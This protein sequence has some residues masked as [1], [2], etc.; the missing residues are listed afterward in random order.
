MEELTILNIV[1][2]I[3]TC[4]ANL[5][6]YLRE[7][8]IALEKTQPSS[9]RLN[10]IQVN[11]GKRG[12]PLFDYVVRLEYLEEKYLEENEQL[13]SLNKLLDMRLKA[14]GEYEDILQ[15]LIKLR[16]DDKKSWAE[17]ERDYIDTYKL[18][19]S[20]STCRRI[21]KRYTG[22]RCDD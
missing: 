18:Y 12:D 16:V 6:Y 20:L 11:G 5:E 3:R 8:D 22:K 21:W 9:K 17:I 4:E 15:L 13:A 14:S 7:K 10:A 2:Q 1:K 19:V